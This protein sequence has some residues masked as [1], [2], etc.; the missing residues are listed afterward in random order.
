VARLSKRRQV[1]VVALLLML[2]PAAGVSALYAY[3]ARFA[4]FT[5]DAVLV[6]AVT[7][8]FSALV[9]V[10]LPWRRP[11]LW[12]AS[13]ASQVR[14]LGVP[15]VPVAGLVTIAL[16]GFNLYEWLADDAYGVNNPASL[17]FM[18]ALYVLAIAV[19][20]AGHWARKRQGTDLGLVLREVPAD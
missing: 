19:Y 20:I 9:A 3:W 13:P 7:Y 17:A 14:V 4:T 18:G 2:V 12:R 6:I 1:P 11:D 10:V 8:M 16:I 15:V 5:L